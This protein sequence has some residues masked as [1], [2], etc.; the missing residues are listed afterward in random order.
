ME[1]YARV[2]ADKG[3]NDGKKV[4]VFIGDSYQ[5]PILG[6]MNNHPAA[7]SLAAYIQFQEGLKA[8]GIQ[9]ACVQSTE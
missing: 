9:I 4:F 5:L 8:L 3:S 6:R 2:T 1:Q 7:P